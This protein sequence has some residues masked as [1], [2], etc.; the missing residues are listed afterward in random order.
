MAVLLSALTTGFTCC[1]LISGIPLSLFQVAE[2]HGELMEFN[3]LLQR[4][5][6]IRESQLKRVTNELV[7]LRGPVSSSYLLFRC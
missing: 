3:E 4:Q 6:I 2:M 7:N 5:L 1:L